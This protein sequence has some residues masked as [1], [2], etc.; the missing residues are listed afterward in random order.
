MFKTEVAMDL[1]LRQATRAGGRCRR[2]RRSALFA[3]GAPAAILLLG[4]AVPV[5]ATTGRSSGGGRLDASLSRIAKLAERQLQAPARR[6]ARD[7]PGEAKQ[8]KALREPASTTEAQVGIVLD[9]LRQMSVPAGLDP[10]YL[11]AL[12]A[13]GRAFVAVSGQDPLTRTAINPDYAGLEAE[14]AASEARLDR[15]AGDAGGVAA[16]VERLTRALAGAQRHAR[17]LERRRRAAG[18]RARRGP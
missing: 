15:S 4:A 14:L 3:L 1:E 6:L 18:A 8:L 5:L 13:A 11:P 7:L 2:G 17:R 9:E 12:V 10:H 16:A